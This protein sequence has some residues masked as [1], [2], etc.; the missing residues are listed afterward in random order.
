MNAELVGVSFA[1]APHEAAY[2]PVAHR[3]PGAPDQLDRDAVLARLRPLLEDPARPK[4]GRTSSRHEHP[5]STASALPH[6]L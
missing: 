1:V 2:V 4:S 6:R 3:Y 5:A